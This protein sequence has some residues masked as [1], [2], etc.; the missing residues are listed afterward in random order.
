MK[1]PESYLPGTVRPSSRTILELSS[2]P[3]HGIVV[4]QTTHTPFSY[5]M[6]FGTL[7]PRCSVPTYIISRSTQV[8]LEPT[9]SRLTAA[10]STIELLGQMGPV[11]FERTTLRLRAA[12]SCPLSYGPDTGWSSFWFAAPI[13]I[14]LASRAFHPTG[15]D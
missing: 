1:T 3:N 12:C 5:V 15:H 14:Q 11:R 7:P 13:A 9:T 2:R 10:G 8:G 4:C 6:P